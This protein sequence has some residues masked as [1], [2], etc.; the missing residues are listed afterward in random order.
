MMKIHAVHQV[1]SLLFLQPPRLGLTHLPMV[2]YRSALLQLVLPIKMEDDKNVSLFLTIC[3]KIHTTLPILTSKGT[4]TK[5]SCFYSFQK[6]IK[7]FNIQF[8]TNKKREK[9]VLVLRF[10]FSLK[11]QTKR[12][13]G[14]SFSNTVGVEELQTGGKI[15][16]MLYC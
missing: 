4:A 16:G 13:S 1:T 10:H 5:R 6:S 7:V 9:I 14:F 3:H 12:S 15:T 2:H 8:S 11:S